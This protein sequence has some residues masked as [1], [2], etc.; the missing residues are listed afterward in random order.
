MPW[1]RVLD[2]VQPPTTRYTGMDHDLCRDLRERHD[3]GTKYVEQVYPADD[4]S[5]GIPTPPCCDLRPG[6]YWD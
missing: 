5:I 1:P 4:V 3:P 2:T 6:L